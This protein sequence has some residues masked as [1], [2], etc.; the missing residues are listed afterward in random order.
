MPATTAPISRDASPAP[1][2][3]G[4]VH[5]ALTS[6]KPSSRIRSPAIAASFPSRRRPR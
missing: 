4:S 6:V 5:T 2:Y 3:A 1:R